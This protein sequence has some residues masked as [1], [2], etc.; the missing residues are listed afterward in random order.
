[1]PLEKIAKA[2]EK[3]AE[4]S[5]QIQLSAVSTFMIGKYTLSE[6]AMIVSIV[7]GVSTMLITFA[8]K[9]RQDGRDQERRRE[10]KLDRAARETE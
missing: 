6:I 8:F 10:E 9:L 1:M 4:H 2:A 3:I 5:T 7:V